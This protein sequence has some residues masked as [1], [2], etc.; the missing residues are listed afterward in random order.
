METTNATADGPTVALAGPLW[1]ESLINWSNKP[2][3]GSVVG[4]FGAIPEG[5]ADL[6]VTGVVTGGGTWHLVLAGTDKDSLGFRSREAG[7]DHAPRL[8]IETVPVTTT[9]PTTAPTTTTTTRPTTTTSAPTTTTVPPTTTTTRPPV[10]TTTTT[11]TRP[12]SSQ[13]CGPDWADA[14]NVGKLPSGQAEM[15]GLVASPAFPGW[16]W[17]VQDSGHNPSLWAI[18][19]NSWGGAVEIPVVGARNSDWEDAAYTKGFAGVGVVSVLENLGNSYTG[20]RRIY[21]V[22]E[23]DPRLSPPL[24][25]VLLGTYQWA[26]PD[27]QY[28]SETL[29]AFGNE[30]AVIAK[31]SPARV[32]QFTEPLSPT[33]VNVPRFVGLLAQGS[34]LSVAA[35]SRDE[36]TLAVASHN[37]VFIYENDGDVED[38]GDLIAGQPIE[39]QALPDDNREGGSFFPYGSCDVVLVAESKNIWRLEED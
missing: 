14:D 6:D 12:P 32:Y 31:T 5:W 23:P 39:S 19:A 11:T 16:G 34:N 26:Y 25:A 10:T 4:D 29:F 30:L 37:K 9:T 36:R 22:K 18:K 15:S 33:R 35:L 21:Q 7:A 8:M 38:L 20:N 2:T 28:N 3:S 1:S 13:H 24:P 17:G 27:T